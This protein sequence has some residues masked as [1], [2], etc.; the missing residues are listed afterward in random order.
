MQTTKYVFVT[1]GV[2]SG[3]GKGLTVASLGR[4]LKARGYKVAT[5]KFDPY[6]NIDPS[7]LNPRE[8]GEIFVTDDGAEA[9]LDLGHY[10][11]F[12]DVSLT[13]N[14]A[15]TMG[16]VYST[17]LDKERKGLY[18]GAT[19]QVVPHITN[20]I[21]VRIRRQADVFEKNGGSVGIV[22]TE[23][24][25]TVGDIESLPI[26]EAIRQ[27]AHDAGRENVVFV[28]TTLVPHLDYIGEIKTK[29]TQH[30]VKEL[31]S[32]GIQPDIVVCRSDRPI[33][34][35][36]KAKL[37]LFCNI[38]TRCIIQNLHAES[39]YEVPLLL[40]DEG[41]ADAV[42][43]KL[44][45]EP[46]WPDLAEWRALVNKCKN[47]KSRVKVGLV[48]RY[49]YSQDAYLSIAEAISHAG[50]HQ[51][52]HVDIEAYGE[53]AYLPDD[54][55]GIILAGSIGEGPSAEMAKAIEHAFKKGIPLF[56]IGNGIE[57]ALDLNGGEQIAGSG[58][59]SCRL[60]KNGIAHMAYGTDKI[61]ERFRSRIALPGIEYEGW[62]VSK[63]GT[64]VES[65]D[66]PWMVCVQFH[67]E[68][69]SRV[70]KP[71]PLFEAFVRAACARRHHGIVS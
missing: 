5:Q 3:L 48:G 47:P 51:E 25:G 29:P 64:V 1:G 33:P 70:T 16:K 58:A 15:M 42:C 8:H 12:T 17:V 61:E 24:G 2:V 14:S 7:N 71:S 45:L 26:L 21:M 6:I 10:E 43:R 34:A 37:A 50:I 4:L 56:G 52:V 44:N 65:T 39:L 46:R 60:I 13:E 30:S 11:R 23:V 19:V 41:F 68:Y 63:D 18:D 69:K 9:D 57:V 22:I 67:P 20:E 31:L 35:D 27:I 53:G 40:E 38:E 32:R 49:A 55:D 28:H 36:A 66:H 62:A 54:L 59:K